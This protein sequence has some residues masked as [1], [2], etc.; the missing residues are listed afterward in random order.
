MN[1]DRDKNAFALDVA[2]GQPEAGRNVLDEGNNQFGCRVGSDVSQNVQAGEGCNGD[3]VGCPVGFL[4]EVAEDQSPVETF[5]HRRHQDHGA[6]KHQ[7]IVAPAQCG[8]GFI[9]VV[10]IAGQYQAY[11]PVDGVKA[12]IVSHKSQ[13][14]C[15]QSV[16]GM[17]E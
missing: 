13:N 11:H 9:V 7:K 12:D 1:E 10:G 8:N 6:D 3:A 2:P 5:F 4:V 16:N 15:L 14:G 17:V